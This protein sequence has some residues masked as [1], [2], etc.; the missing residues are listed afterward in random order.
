MLQTERILVATDFSASAERARRQ[1]EHLAAVHNAAL[2][3]LHVTGDPALAELVEALPE[4]KATPRRLQAYLAEWLGRPIEPPSADSTGGTQVRDETWTVRRGQALVK[5]II[6]YADE[7][8]ADLLLMGTGR[9][10]A[11]LVRRSRRPVITVPRT[12]EADGAPR[13]PRR[14]PKRTLQRILVPVDF[15]VVTDPLVRHAWALA[16]RSGASVDLVHVLASASLTRSWRRRDQA[17]HT[18]ERAHRA[19][20]ILADQDQALSVPVRS[21]VLSGNPAT[22]ITEYAEE[23]QADLILMGTHGRTGLK[24]VVLGSVAEEVIQSAP[25]P[26]GTLKND[27]HSLVRQDIRPASRDDPVRSERQTRH[28]VGGLS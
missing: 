12:E 22:A 21:R 1:A 4:E 6:K 18:A 11:S 13:V 27:G 28:F 20:T 19:L 3:V 16:T 5:G 23:Q 24:R 10:T 14:L 7:I 8:D 17:P 26:V 2:N 15:S 9:R 25:C